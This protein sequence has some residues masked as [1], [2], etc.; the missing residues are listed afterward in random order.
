MGKEVNIDEILTRSHKQA[1][2]KK[3]KVSKVIDSDTGEQMES[4]PSKSKS[5]QQPG[6]GAFGGPQG[7]PGNFSEIFN[8]PEVTKMF[9]SGAIPGYKNLP[10]KQRIMFKLMGFFSKPGRSNLLKKRWWPLW[11]IV[12]IL[13]F[14]FILVAVILFAIFKLGKAIVMPYIN[15]FRKKS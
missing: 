4:P 15:I 8:N 5:K 7:M 2:E 3:P 13:L 14:A 10:L 11:A 9:S 6:F 12:L 1:E